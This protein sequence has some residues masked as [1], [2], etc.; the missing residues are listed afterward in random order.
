MPVIA[1][2]PNGEQSGIVWLAILGAVAL[3]VA[4][5]YGL[6]RWYEK[7]Y[8]KGHSGVITR[9]GSAMAE[10]QTLLEPAN[11][12]MIEVK[13]QRRDGDDAGDDPNPSH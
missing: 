11:R 8:G 4:I 13:K 7:V 1:V 3:I 10:L 2:T 5:L 6:G 12:H 9:A